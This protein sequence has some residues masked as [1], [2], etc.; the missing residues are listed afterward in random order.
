MVLLAALPLQPIHISQGEREKKAK[1]E[2]EKK[3]EMAVHPGARVS[4]GA[5]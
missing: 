1:K 4:L 3:K 2:S 5:N